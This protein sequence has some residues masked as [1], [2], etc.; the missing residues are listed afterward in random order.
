MDAQ[1]SPTSPGWIKPGDVM[2][3]RKLK[4]KRK[5]LQARMSALTP[6]QILAP[7]K[8]LSD[9]T[10]GRGIKRRNP[11][12]C[13][14]NKKQRA[15]EDGDLE[16]TSDASLFRMLSPSAP[17]QKA[18]SQQVY[19][20]SNILKL[21][22]QEELSLETEEVPSVTWTEQLAVDWSLKSRVRFKSTKPLPW[23]HNFKT[24]EEASGTT[25]FV[26]CLNSTSDNSEDRTLD[27][28]P[29]AQFYQCCLIWQYP[30]LPWLQLFPRDN[31]KATTQTGLFGTDKKLGDAIHAEWS[32]SLR[33]LHQL[34]RVRQCPYF[35]VCG[36]TFTCLFR[37]AG[38]AGISQ[39]HALITPTTRG[40]RE[41]MRN[42]DIEFEMPFHNNG[43]KNGQE[44]QQ[45][46]EEEEE[47]EEEKEEEAT[48]WL[49]NLGVET[50]QF[51]N[52]NPNRVKLEREKFK[53]VDKTAASLVYVEGMETQ[54]LINFLLNSRSCVGTTGLLAGVPPTLLSPVAFQGSTLKTLKAKGSVIRQEGDMHHSMEVS[55]PILPHTVHQLCSLLSLAT[56]S[57][58]LSLVPVP[59]TLPF[60]QHSHHDATAAPQA[61]AQEGLVDCGF[62]ASVRSLICTPRR[63]EQE[64]TDL[65]S[66]YREVTYKDK[67]FTWTDKLQ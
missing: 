55:G 49:E 51:P 15:E 63:A 32:E 44:P 61:F 67:K 56:D 21:Q 18:S 34:L 11:F 30:S 6:L 57:Y 23:K 28:S 25:G 1:P 46:D 48:S 13:S 27:T 16:I 4:A 36:P 47:E 59:S 38:V 43:T 65:P 17:K 54:G 24:S 19:S 53:N 64:E 42:E 52:L 20:F 29:N 37:A 14:P 58:T 50:S 33:S 7:A 35:Y 3:V 60:S 41:A 10:E 45:E 39:A 31:L 66:T 22:Q 12:K 40:F 62:D 26:R 8:G 2:R 5:A 9:A